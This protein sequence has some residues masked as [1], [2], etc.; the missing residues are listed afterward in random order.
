MFQ[1]KRGRRIAVLSD[2]LNQKGKT[3][4]GSYSGYPSKPLITVLSKKSTLIILKRIPGQFLAMINSGG[5]R[6]VTLTVLTISVLF[7]GSY[8]P[9]SQG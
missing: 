7:A 4:L 8:S 2:N 5:T 6:G 1:W 3:S 9:S